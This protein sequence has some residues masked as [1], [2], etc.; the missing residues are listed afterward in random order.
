MRCLLGLLLCLTGGTVGLHAEEKPRP[1]LEALVASE[2]AFAK[3]SVDQG[4]KAAFLANLAEDAIL[5]R[6]RVVNGPEF[7]RQ[8]PETTAVLEWEPVFA[9]ISASGDLGYTT[10]PWKL[11]PKPGAPPTKFGHY[12]SLWRKQPDGRFK[13][14]LDVGIPHASIPSPALTY[15]PA[16]GP[17]RGTATQ[18]VTLEE[19]FF[20]DNPFADPKSF[21]DL[22][23]VLAA[24]EAR[25]YREGQPPRHGEAG[26]K[27]WEQ[28]TPQLASWDM[29]KVVMAGSGDLAYAY[30]QVCIRGQKSA[31][32]SYLRIWRYRGGDWKI[33]LD[34][35]NR[36]PVQEKPGSHPL[37]FTVRTRGAAVAE[38]QPTWQ[39]SATALIVCDVWDKHW[40]PA[41]SARVDELVPRMNK[42]IEE[43][44]KKGVLIIHAPSE[45]MKFYEGSPQRKLA[46]TAP[47]A[48]NQPKDIA[49][50]LTRLP[51]EPKLPIDD[52][53]N[54]CDCDPAPKPHQ[55][56]T[57]QHS[58]IRIADGDAVSDSGVEIWNL[59][60]QRGIRNVMILGVHT[61]MCVLGR[62]FGL[63]QMARNGKNVVL[64]R[65][66]TDAMYNP[67]M[68]PHVSHRRG[69]EMVIEHIERH[70]CG[71]IHSADIL[72]ERQQPHVV[73][74]IGEGEYQ[75][76]KT[77]PEF[78]R[79]ELQPYGIR[80]TF[81]HADAKNPNDF[82]GL[83][84]IKHADLVFLSV[85]RRSL[86]D[87]QLGL[88]RD[89]LAAGKPLI[90]IRTASHA[91]DP[92]PPGPGGSWATFDLDVLGGKYL[93][94]YGSKPPQPPV[95]TVVESAKD[96]P[97]LRGILPQGFKAP[98]HLYKNRDLTATATPL[99]IGH[100]EGQA[101]REPVAWTNTY[102]GGRIFY[103]SLGSPADFEIVAFRTLLR[104]AVLWA[105]DRPVPEPK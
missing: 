21:P 8:M 79:K 64:V 25:V 4:I 23:R 41:A 76:E 31:V 63:R 3:M 7:Y 85:R 54:G 16:S 105:L 5:F 72:G 102:K 61:N 104:N 44:R 60:E 86:S 33:V 84:V 40:C 18:L 15:A 29:T 67:K 38:K 30:G 73:F 49:K 90:G 9:D 92:K 12:V 50:W 6:P 28:S 88:L 24:P 19:K 32:A 56:W 26:R 59:L 70:V 55:A 68:P 43:A 34:L 11:R 91:F 35:E 57:R 48:A 14:I 95:I 53:D 17:S 1:E 65:D 75:T 74:V 100:L 27:L 62:P 94:H 78:A 97:I 82:P 77:L 58:G 42:V 66:L 10:G 2:R 83:E 98:S 81:V 87:K 45:C 52:S 20:N 13:V 80:C 69:T 37:A 39:P 96:H 71:T 93:G 22:Y 46:Q 101:V 89:Y 99:L 47:K 103:T 51:E 36:V